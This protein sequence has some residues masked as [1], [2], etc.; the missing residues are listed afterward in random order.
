MIEYRHS[1]SEERAVWNLLKHVET[2]IVVGDSELR[3][4]VAFQNDGLLYRR[5]KD[6]LHSRQLRNRKSFS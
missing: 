4:Y 6:F 2:P 1:K 5:K 3:S